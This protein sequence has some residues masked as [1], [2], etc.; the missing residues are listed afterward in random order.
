M[1]ALGPQRDL[2]LARYIK[3]GNA[4][5]ALDFLSGNK[6]VDV[7]WTDLQGIDL[8]ERCKGNFSTY[9]IEKPRPEELLSKLNRFSL[10]SCMRQGPLGVDALNRYFLH[11]CLNEAPRDAWWVAP[12][13]ITRNDYELELL[14]AISVFLCAKSLVILH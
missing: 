12:V 8:W 3:E 11:R 14:M 13:M 9:Y 4:N 7:S 5:A 10:L 2:E 1:P 6:T